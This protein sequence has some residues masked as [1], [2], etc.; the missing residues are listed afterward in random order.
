MTATIITKN[1]STASAVPT[2]GQLQTAEIALNTADR[3][4]FTKDATNAVVQLVGTLGNQDANNVAIDT[5]VKLRSALQDTGGD[6]DKAG[7][8]LSAFTKFIDSA[9]N[10]SFEAQKTLLPFF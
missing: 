9:A 1:N 4:L 8:M 10:G 6:A 2:A 5:V 3:K 7:I